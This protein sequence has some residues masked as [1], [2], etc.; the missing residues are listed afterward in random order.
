MGQWIV[1]LVD[2]LFV[3]KYAVEHHLDKMQSRVTFFFVDFI[4]QGFAITGNLVRL[5]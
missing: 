2:G 5:T 4:R 3:L 1:D